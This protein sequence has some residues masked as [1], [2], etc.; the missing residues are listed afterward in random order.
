[1]AVTGESP[2]RL[3]ELFGK[4]AVYDTVKDVVKDYRQETGTACSAGGRSLRYENPGISPGSSFSTMPSPG[5][6]S[7]T[8][9]GARSRSQPSEGEALASPL[10]TYYAQESLMRPTTVS[11]KEA[12]Q[13]SQ[14]TPTSIAWLVHSS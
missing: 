13:N 3:L 14:R 1:M 8:G 4:N 12:T 6:S 9:S 10:P 11:T 2:Y 5:P 7:T